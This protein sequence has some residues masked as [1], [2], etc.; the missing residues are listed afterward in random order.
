M[1]NIR[2]VDGLAQLL[3]DPFLCLVYVGLGLVVLVA[4]AGVA[5]RRGAAAFVETWRFDGAGR[6][7]SGREVAHR[8]AFLSALGASVGVGNLAGVATAIHLGGPGALFWM[9][10]SAGLG[11]SFRMVS[12]YLAIRH[13]PSD[14][15][16]PGVATP[17][18]YLERF[19]PR[20]CR[21]IP[22]IV[23]VLLLASGVINANLIQ[24][25][26]IAHTLTLDFGVSPLV[27][28]LGLSLGL[29]A[30]VVGGL[31]AIVG[32]C[33]RAAP[34]MV[35][36][37]VG[38]G[39]LALASEPAAALRSLDAV[40]VY[41]IRPYAVAGG[42]GGY[43]VLRSVQYG[44]S[45]GI[46][47][48]GAGMGT[49][50]F[51]QGANTDDPARGAYM[52]A[53]VPALD[54]L[55]VCTVT[56]LVILTFGMWPF[57]TGAHLTVSAFEVALGPVGK[58][59]VLASL[60]TFAFTTVASWAHFSER[61]FEYLGGRDRATYRVVFCAVSFFGPFFPVAWVWSMAD[62]LVGLLMV[63]HLVPLTWIAVRRA[64]RILADLEPVSS[65]VPRRARR[66]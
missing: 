42:V 45:R 65:P 52:A 43:A 47:S 56:G 63:A 44:V 23:A 16:D 21:S 58:L 12:T 46:F 57:W 50:P 31:H 36:L 19:L 41:A 39:L 59:V 34:W 60:V 22:T 30:V 15:S 8:D 3:W 37:Y 53:M 7:G 35:G 32:F 18:A 1:V 48:H 49:A 38:A 13:R 51:F 28:A 24:S 2:A 55:V 66:V 61:C 33:A 40:F 64:P 29:M 25:N 9:W 4:T 17:M 62:V 54:T 10:V 5:W 20:W 27:V 6:Q 26:S 14:P 11:V